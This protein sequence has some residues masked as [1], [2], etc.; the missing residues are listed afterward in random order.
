MWNRKVSSMN[1]NYFCT[2]GSCLFDGL[3][4]DEE[5]SVNCG[6]WNSF[7]LKFKASL[8]KR[9]IRVNMQLLDEY[10]DNKRLH[11]LLFS[12]RHHLKRLG[13]DFSKSDFKDFD[14]ESKK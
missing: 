11:I 10:I 4:E 2:N 6:E 13:F 3:E 12:E 8:S 14:L 5:Y 9:H 7:K 1:N